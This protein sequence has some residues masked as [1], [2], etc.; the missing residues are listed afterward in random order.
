VGTLLGALEGRRDEGTGVERSVGGN[1]GAKVG[2][3]NVGLLVGR[4][5][6]IEVIGRLVDGRLVELDNVGKIVGQRVVGL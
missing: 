5:V 2:V 6:G 4:K 1:D 3:A